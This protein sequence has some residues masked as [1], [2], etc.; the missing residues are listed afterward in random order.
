V[1]DC[2]SV[3]VS[4]ELSANAAG[5]TSAFNVEQYQIFQF[6]HPIQVPLIQA[7]LLNPPLRKDPLSP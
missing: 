1:H 4:L 7:P 6:H 5:K 3:S 2:V